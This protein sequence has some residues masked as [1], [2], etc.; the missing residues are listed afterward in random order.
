MK[1]LR[2]FSFP[3]MGCLWVFRAPRVLDPRAPGVCSILPE[4]SGYPGYWTPGCPV[5][6]PNVSGW[7]GCPVP[8]LRVPGL[9]G[10]V[11]DHSGC[12]GS[13]TPGC[14][15][16]RGI[17]SDPTGCPGLWTMIFMLRNQLRRNERVDVATYVVRRV[18]L[19]LHALMVPYPTLL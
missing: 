9:H 10:K 15:V 11:S 5:P 8:L 2:V 14:P 13:W 12:P 3:V 6:W 16:S 19:L 4:Q 18:I 17:V 7:S 1:K